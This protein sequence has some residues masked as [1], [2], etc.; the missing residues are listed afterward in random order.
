MGA[1]AL[2]TAGLAV[3]ASVTAEIVATVPWWHPD[4][5]T[6]WRNLE[7]A[8][9][10]HPKIDH[11]FR[12]ANG[13]PSSHPNIDEEMAEWDEWEDDHGLITNWVR[14]LTMPAFNKIEVPWWHP[15]VD[16]SYHAGAPKYPPGHPDTQAMF[17]GIVPEF[18]PNLD[19]ILSAAP[20]AFSSTHPRIGTFLAQ[21]PM[22]AF[23]NIQVP[24]WHPDVKTSYLSGNPTLPPNHPDVHAMFSNILPSFHPNVDGQMA[25]GGV[26][27]LS[28]TH[29][30]IDSFIDKLP[31]PAFDKIDVPWWHPDV[32]LA[33]TSDAPKYPPGHPD[34][35]AMLASITPPWHPNVD[36][37]MAMPGAGVLAET[38]PD[39]SAMVN[40]LPMPA[41]RKAVPW[42]HPEVTASY[43]LGKPVYP[44]G[45]PEISP[46]LAPVL[47]AF[48]P[49][50]DT[51]FAV[52]G[53]GF[54]A[55]TH[56]NIDD[57]LQ[58]VAA[59]ATVQISVPWWH[60][61]V[62]LAFENGDPSYPPGHPVTQD[63]LTDV[64]PS[65]HPNVDTLMAST[66][67]YKLAST[68]PS[69]NDFVIYEPR[70]AKAVPFPVPSWHPNITHAWITGR[71]LPASHPP[72]HPMLTAQL[73]AFHPNVDALLK[74]PSAL[75][76][77]HPDL[78]IFV[79]Y[80]PISTLQKFGIPHWH[81]LLSEVWDDDEGIPDGHPSVHAMF[82]TVGS[83][84]ASHPSIDAYFGRGIALDPS[85]PALDDLVY[86]RS[87]WSAGKIMGVLLAS[88]FALGVFLRLCLKCHLYDNA[89]EAQGA[90]DFDLSREQL[91]IISKRTKA[92]QKAK[93]QAGTEAEHADESAAED[94]LK[95]AEQAAARY[96]DALDDHTFPSLRRGSSHFM[97]RGA[98]DDDDD[99][100]EGENKQVA[101]VEEGKEEGKGDEGAE[102]KDVKKEEGAAAAQVPENP[103][104]EDKEEGTNNED[105]EMQALAKPASGLKRRAKRGSALDGVDLEHVIVPE[106]RVP[107]RDRLV[108][109]SKLLH[110]QHRSELGLYADD[111]GDH[112]VPPLPVTGIKLRSDVLEAKTQSCCRMFLTMVTSCRLPK[113][114]WTLGNGI[115]ISIYI[116]LNIFCLFAYAVRAQERLFT[117]ETFARGF[118]SLA[119]VNTMAII[120]P[121]TRN[122]VLTWGL[123]LP[124]D[125]VVLYHRVLGR[126]TLT[127][128]VIHLIASV[129]M[130]QGFESD[131]LWL[132]GLGSAACG[133][134]ISMTSFDYMRR[135][136]F[137]I[138]FF[139]HFSFIGYYGLA[140]LH[141]E[142]TKPFLGIGVAFYLLDRVLR[143]VTSA[144]PKQTMAFVNK[145]DSIA[146]V[147]FAKNP[148][149]S[150]LGMHKTGQYFFVNFPKL[151]LMEW[152]PFSVS[153][154]PREDGVELHI[155]ALGDHTKEVVALSKDCREKEIPT[156]IRI[157]GPYGVHD[158][159]YRRYP[160]LM[161]VGGGVGI[162]PVIGILK[163]IYNVG[164]YSST[165][166]GRVPPHVM[167]TV[168]CIWCMPYEV[169]AGCFLEELKECMANAQL[170]PQ[171]PALKVW[172][173]VTR[174]KEDLAPPLIKGRPKFPDILD[175]MQ[176]QHPDKAI[177]TFACG[178][179]RMVAELWDQS[180]KRTAKGARIDFHHETFEF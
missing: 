41:W 139:S 156:W 57:L 22:P 112:V 148:L 110:A 40:V 134:I 11:K 169:D 46:M 82:R 80:L 152:H 13:Y 30:D 90:D 154:G 116:G 95:E 51:L 170:C 2:L 178:P 61:D 58:L 133:F 60:P 157:E 75:T 119:A 91:A 128:V 76:A 162:T 94:G 55:E 1:S 33:F 107:G 25:A 97:K 138:F 102:A 114:E 180:V 127:C 140:F 39:I 17:A 85:H 69:L 126:W 122:S 125:H 28:D 45:H 47:P 49:N 159:N 78:N 137:N 103:V 14:Y 98:L 87:Q 124:F 24:W 20:K 135:K 84:P 115:F 118:G 174:S 86:L 43:L 144:L 68:H 113:S 10:G 142:D 73:P 161:L 179:S 89:R 48:H 56:P 150:N 120:L 165:E 19:S 83:L 42:W 18:H 147:R 108:A 88:M 27:A 26:H 54:L 168:H 160:V 70:P 123:G 177:L 36:T 151:S 81:P 74:Q 21:L 65:F 158:F 167:Q 9:P 53:P 130:Y 149:T 44:D 153:S 155:R 100:E 62:S 32:S 5:D 172:I 173:Y 64:I 129:V 164:Q 143:L 37:L 96:R 59:P 15:N 101:A 79:E 34:V 12:V 6:A 50:P 29:P 146:Q 92:L 4:V 67:L 23:T 31:M 117:A 3:L 72:V 35:A 171:L 145:G 8:P 106:E 136:C 131:Y 141:S 16:A 163:D 111:G 71:K 166:R 66:G 99:A 63:L 175:T 77:T 93:A 121:A 132:T 176:A 109:T 105:I 104:D 38:H 7:V 52:G